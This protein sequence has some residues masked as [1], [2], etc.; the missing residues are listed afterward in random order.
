MDVAK[1]LLL[2]VIFGRGVADSRYYIKWEMKMTMGL[3]I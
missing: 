3:S 2:I 1:F